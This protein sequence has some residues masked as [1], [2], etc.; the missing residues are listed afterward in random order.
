MLVRKSY[1]KSKMEKT[2][3]DG[4]LG[5][6]STNVRY[7]S[8]TKYRTLPP[9]SVISDIQ[10]KATHYIQNAINLRK[11]Q[12]LVDTLVRESKHRLK[13]VCAPHLLELYET[14]V[15]T[16]PRALHVSSTHTKKN[17][18]FKTRFSLAEGIDYALKNCNP[19]HF[20][21]IMLPYS[22]KTRTD[23]FTHAN[24]IYIH[25]KKRSSLT[26]RCNMVTCYLLEPNGLRFTQTY[27][28]GITKLQQAWS[29]V[30]KHSDN[31]RVEYVERVHIIGEDL[32]TQYGL[33]TL[34]GSD[35]R[36]TI[37][38]GNRVYR[39]VSRSGYG[40]CGAVTLW[41]FRMW[42]RSSTS[43]SLEDYYR[44]LHAFTESNR[45][46]AQRM[47]MS[48]MQKIN[49][50]VHTDYAE[51]TSDY[52]KADVQT[53]RNHLMTQYHSVLQSYGCVMT[54]TYDM[55]FGTG[56]RRLMV[57]KGVIMVLE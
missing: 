20:H 13:K 30:A 39:S 51:R 46:K 6:I 54:L 12:V 18:L 3:G 49:K 7:F 40:I 4:V 38:K 19:L 35:Q 48:F 28:Y 37:R 43:H 44:K 15:P 31:N 11:Q 45:V 26:R 50:R 5:S 33:Q 22:V 10:R 1:R 47:I 9:Q 16:Q 34:L 23:N 57:M 25:F 32:D 21:G 24:L 27:P 29:Y 42:I 8:T 36:Q 55:E 2:Y 56:R 17:V 14:I 53:I 41:V 52:I